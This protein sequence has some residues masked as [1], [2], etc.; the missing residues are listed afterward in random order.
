MELFQHSKLQHFFYQESRTIFLQK[1]NFTNLNNKVDSQI[2]LSKIQNSNFNITKSL[3]NV[4]YFF[5][6]FYLRASSQFFKS[7]IIMVEIMISLCLLYIFGSEIV[8]LFITGSLSLVVCGGCTS[9][10]AD[11]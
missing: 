11:E 1:C 6:D 9:E 2:V 5:L 4:Y 3:N 7:L 10:R 8:S